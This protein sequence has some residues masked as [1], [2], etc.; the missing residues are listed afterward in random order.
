VPVIAVDENRTI[1]G[2]TPAMMGFDNVIEA[3]GYA[4]AAGIVM[5]LKKGI[6]LESISRPLNTIRYQVEDREL[7]TSGVA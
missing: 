2:I 4:E 3:H 6:N 1:L 7:V 5:A